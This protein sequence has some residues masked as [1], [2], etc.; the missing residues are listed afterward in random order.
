VQLAD[1]SSVVV[2][3][4]PRNEMAAEAWA[5]RLLGAAGLPVPRVVALE[6]D[7]GLGGLPTIVLSF[8]AGAP[9]DDPGVL[10]QAGSSMRRV[11]AEQLPGWGPLVVDA[12]SESPVRGRND[13]WRESVLAGLAGLPDLV[14][15]GVV[16]AELA[17]AARSCVVDQMLDYEGPGVLL[18]NDLKLAHVL[19]AGDDREAH[20]S[21]I[22]DWGDASV[23]DPLADLAR[24]SMAGPSAT[25]AFLAGYGLPMTP[26]RAGQLARYRILWNIAAL[27]AEFRAGGDWFRVYRERIADDTR[28]LTTGLV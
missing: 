17:A 2:K 21:A 24:L 15:A 16:D 14:S 8:V 20:L 18:H 19:G 13:T 25:E 6:P 28:L 27:T 3:S 7:A 11:H 12:G 5:C 26:A 23:G 22:I 10:Y 4:G 9:S 1:S